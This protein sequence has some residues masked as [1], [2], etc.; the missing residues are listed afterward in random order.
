MSLISAMACNCKSLWEE[1]SWAGT[2]KMT[3]AKTI[4]ENL[5]MRIINYMCIHIFVHTY[6]ALPPPLVEWSV[7]PR[8]SDSV[9]RA[10]RVART[11]W[12]GRRTLVL[13]ALFWNLVF[14]Y[15]S[16]YQYHYHSWNYLHFFVNFDMEFTH[17]CP[18]HPR[19]ITYRSALSLLLILAQCS[20]ALSFNI[21]LS[22]S[23]K[24]M[25]GSPAAIVWCQ[26]Y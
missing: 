15:L 14:V 21:S 26:S 12:G 7:P 8:R 18:C 25:M 23:N 1:R 4:T 6:L 5:C 13:S 22:I 17:D 2:A 16:I 10:S 11:V 9:G 20:I 19:C 24:I 3:W